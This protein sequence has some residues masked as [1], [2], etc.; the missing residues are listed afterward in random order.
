MPRR[1][2]F[3][4]NDSTNGLS[5]EHTWFESIE[6]RLGVTCNPFV[7]EGLAID[8]NDDKR[9]SRCSNLLNHLYLTTIEV[10]RWTVARLTVCAVAPL[11]TQS[12]TTDND[13]SQTVLFG[14]LNHL[15]NTCIV[16]RATFLD[17]SLLNVGTRCGNII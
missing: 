11:I 10:D 17:I 2:H 7:V 14:C 16:D 1:I 12:V 6:H 3:A 13:D 8:D 9:Y 5:T 15:R 4:C